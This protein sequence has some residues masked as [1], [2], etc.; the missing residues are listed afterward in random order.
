MHSVRVG[1]KTARAVSL[2]RQTAPPRSAGSLLVGGVKSIGLCM[3]VK[4]ESKLILRCLESVRPI[5]DYV[6][7]EDTGSTDGTQTIIREWLARVGLQG[8]VYNEPWR[9]F[10]HNR[11]SV[12]K[13]L[14]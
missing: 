9:D 8:E 7:I 13:R 11:S 6:L 10:A 4:N 14:R 12:L 2:K 5:V 1:P 3:I